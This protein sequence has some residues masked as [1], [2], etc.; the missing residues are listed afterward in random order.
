MVAAAIATAVAASTSK[1]QPNADAGE[2]IDFKV[3]SSFKFYLYRKTNGNHPCNV[4]IQTN[5]VGSSYTLLKL[6]FIER[7]YI[8]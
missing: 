6:I 2:L 4:A 5:K 3:G 8:Y 7:K 1:Q